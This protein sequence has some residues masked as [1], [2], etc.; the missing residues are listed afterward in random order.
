M[1]TSIFQ[2]RVM[3]L[4]VRK[5]YLGH[6]VY[7][8]FFNFKMFMSHCLKKNLEG[9]MPACWP[10]VDHSCVITKINDRPLTLSNP[11][12]SHIK[13]ENFMNLICEIAFERDHETYIIYIQNIIGLNNLWIKCVIKVLSK[14]WWN[15]I[16]WPNKFNC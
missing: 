11:R 9:P 10:Q 8:F 1:W 14:C 16:F 6:F 3:L 2:F 4:F 13:M 15:I 12:I 7:H 5:K